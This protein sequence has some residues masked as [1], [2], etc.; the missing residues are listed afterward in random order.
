MKAAVLEGPRKIVVKDVAKPIAN[1]DEVLIKIQYCGI[2]GSDL[3][4]YKLGAPAGRIIGHEFS[5]NI[6]ELGSAVEKWRV[7][8]RVSADPHTAC[9]NCYWCR[10]GKPELCENI[11]VTGGEQLEGAFATYVKVKSDQLVIVPEELTFEQGALLEPLAIAVHTVRLSEIKAG[12]TVAVLGLGPMGQFTARIAK[13]SGASAVYATDI[14]KPRLDLARNVVDEAIDSNDVDSTERI[15]ELTND[16]GPDIVF[17]CAGN[18]ATLEQ[19]VTLVRRG[20]TIVVLGIYWG[21]LE[22]EPRNLV[23]KELT[24][25]GSLHCSLVDFT[26]AIGLLE[27]KRIEVDSLITSK[28]ALEEIAEKGFE[29]A[30]KGEGGKVLV[31]P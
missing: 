24:I 13:A 1:K 10:I 22:V 14:S 18:V 25:K 3:H 11:I 20:G 21:S 23:F 7:G 16:M 5:G 26:L 17:E 12:D 28:I 19:A 6:V 9:H 27:N 30:L 2:C 8:D 31:K 29:V 4:F 15:L